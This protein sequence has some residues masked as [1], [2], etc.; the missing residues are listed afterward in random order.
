VSFLSNYTLQDIVGTVLALFLF[1]IIFIAPG[2]VVGWLMN[3]FDFQLRRP[4]VRFLVALVL[5]FAISPILFFLTLRL[6][7]QI[8]TYLCTPIILIAFFL[9]LYR[10]PDSLRIFTTN[11]H[12]IINKYAKYAFWIAFGLI[13]FVILTLTEIQ[14]GDRIYYNVVAYDYSTR[15]AI[16]N[17]ITKSGIPPINPGFFPGKPVFLTYLYYFWYIP[18]SVV[19]KIGGSWVDARNAM[20]ASV[21]WCGLAFMATI[22]LYLRLRNHDGKVSIWKTAI[23]GIG[24]ITVSGADIIPLVLLVFSQIPYD[25]QGDIEHWNEQITA[26]I[27][28]LSWTPHHI[29]AAIACL[30]G[31]MLFLDAQNKHSAYRVK[32]MVVSGIAFSS[33]FGLSVFVTIVFALLWGIMAFYRLLHKEHGWFLLMI[34]AGAIGLLSISPF[35]LDLFGTGNPEGVAVPLT[36][37]VRTFRP[38]YPF[39]SIFPSWVRNVFYLALLPV[40][41]FLELGFFFIVGVLWLQSNAKGNWN[42]NQ[43][44][45]VEVVLLGI[46]L[47]IG[48]FVRSTVISSN[49]IG[50]R[51][52]LPGQFVL[53]IWG[54]DIIAKFLG[55][56][57]SVDNKA[58]PL[59]QRTSSQLR[60]FLII[61]ILTTLTDVTLLRVWPMVVD[62]GFAR[63]PNSLSTDHQL[64]KRTFAARQMY[65][66]I[67]RNLPQDVIIQTYP[68]LQVDR[69]LGLYSNRQLVVSVHTAFG[70]SMQELQQEITSVSAIFKTTNWN[71]INKSCDENLINILIISDLDKIWESLPELEKSHAPLYKNSYY[72]VFS[73]GERELP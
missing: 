71:S 11:R 16:I 29:A 23:T 41:Y 2:Y 13:V 24:L 9:I 3:L 19:D 64:G 15:V 52:W 55:G 17:A 5:S 8:F 38:I 26:W 68:S 60:I 57:S 45:L 46:T 20:I 12:E 18:C 50:W 40:N 66:Y 28:A 25:F 49:D 6:L 33:A 30:A 48:S 58:S 47:F 43:F 10:T 67:N 72:S 31:V 39:I 59:L 53:L 32:A 36:F 65:E 69:T 44:F 70:I 4:S 7:P 63:T 56:K 27:G 54:T 14:L 1:P 34:F 51:A 37:A 62:S 61:G 22:A 73:C 35:L 21:A 42:K